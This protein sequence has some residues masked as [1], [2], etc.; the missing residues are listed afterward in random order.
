MKIIRLVNTKF[1]TLLPSI[2]F[3]NARQQ[4]SLE[5]VFLL[6]VTYYIDDF[7]LLSVV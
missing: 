4:I 3:Q 7:G 5:S 6:M 1:S 2:I